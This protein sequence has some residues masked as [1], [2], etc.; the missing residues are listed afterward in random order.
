MA[1]RFQ[2]QVEDMYGSPLLPVTAEVFLWI[3]N[4]LAMNLLL[5]VVDLLGSLAVHGP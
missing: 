4:K 2:H 1:V 3:V 5:V